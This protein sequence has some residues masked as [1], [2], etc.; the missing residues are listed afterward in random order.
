M[1]FDQYVDCGGGVTAHQSP[2][3]LPS[4]VGAYTLYNIHTFAL[5]FSRISFRVRAFVRILL[6]SAAVL[7]AYF[8]CLCAGNA[9]TAKQVPTHVHICSNEMSL[10]VDGYL[11]L[12][13]SIV[14]CAR[15]SSH[16]RFLHRLLASLPP[17]HRR[18]RFFSRELYV[19]RNDSSSNEHSSSSAFHR[20]RGGLLD[21]TTKTTTTTDDGDDNDIFPFFYFFVCNHWK[22]GSQ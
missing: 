15:I 2:N 5:L 22:N 6:S 21:M 19:T 13:L 8:I 17:S 1:K 14:W 4:S 10:H 3:N 11:I 9:A 18:S 20:H 12:G 16:I 7:T